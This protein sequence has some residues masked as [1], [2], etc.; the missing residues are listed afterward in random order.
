MANKQR[1][2]FT[3]PISVDGGEAALKLTRLLSGAEE[4]LPGSE[5]SRLPAA[6]YCPSPGYPVIRWGATGEVGGSVSGCGELVPKVFC[7]V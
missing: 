6:R 3:L 5:S 1:C 4:C 2:L 7:F